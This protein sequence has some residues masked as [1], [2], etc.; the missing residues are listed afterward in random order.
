M[1]SPRDSHESDL[2]QLEQTLHTNNKLAGVDA[3]G[4]AEALRLPS[5]HGCPKRTATPG[6]DCPRR[7]PGSP[8]SGSRPSGE[9]GDAH[10][11]SAEVARRPAAGEQPDSSRRVAP[12]RA[13]EAAGLAFVTPR[14]AWH[15]EK[16]PGAHA[17]LTAVSPRAGH[18]ERARRPPPVAPLPAPF[19]SCC[20]MT[21]PPGRTGVGGWR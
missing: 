4:D 9:G 13:P 7:N 5:S 19:P 6:G 16:R 14:A 11:G 10:A 12:G 1:L 2:G 17:T 3:E 21:R 8:L 18:R 15:T 20:P